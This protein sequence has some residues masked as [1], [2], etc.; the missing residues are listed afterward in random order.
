MSFQRFEAYLVA[1]WALALREDPG[2]AGK[3][4]TSL[5]HACDEKPFKILRKDLSKFTSVK[6][7]FYHELSQLIE[8]RNWL[9]H[10][11][12]QSFSQSRVQ[13]IADRSNQLT[14]RLS[15]LLLE[16]CKKEGMAESEIKARTEEVVEQWAADRNAA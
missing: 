13:S 8:D 1:Y 5:L 15:S 12:F 9:V 11:S 4:V 7:S 14:R 2:S 10:K 16:R 6:E 3:V